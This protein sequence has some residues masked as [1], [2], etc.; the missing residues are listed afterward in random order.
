MSCH[1]YCAGKAS[2]GAFVLGVSRT[3]AIDRTERAIY[4]KVVCAARFPQEVYATTEFTV[5]RG[6]G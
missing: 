3:E 6:S 4:R 5:K 1:F 2:C